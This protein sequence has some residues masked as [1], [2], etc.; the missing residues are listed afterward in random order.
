[1]TSG[2]D[3]NGDV[4]VPAIYAG[5]SEMHVFLCAGYDNEPGIVRDKHLYVRAAWIRREFPEA[6]GL[7]DSVERRMRGPDGPCA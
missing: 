5:V 6:G 2:V 3:A 4:W 7:L 1:L